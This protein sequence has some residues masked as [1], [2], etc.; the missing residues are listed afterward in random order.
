MICYDG[1]RIRPD[2][3]EFSYQHICIQFANG[4]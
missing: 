1:I 4:V 2:K 3:D